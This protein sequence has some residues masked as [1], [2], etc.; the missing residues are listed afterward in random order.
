MWVGIAAVADRLANSSQ[1]TRRHYRYYPKSDDE[2]HF[3][4]KETIDTAAAAAVDTWLHDDRT[5]GEG[6]AASSWSSCR[7]WLQRRN[8]RHTRRYIQHTDVELP[9]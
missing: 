2:H 8:W 6:A 5:D 1:H 3:A 4:E 9:W 7:Q